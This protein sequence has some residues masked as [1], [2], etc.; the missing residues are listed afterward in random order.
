[1]NGGKL[2]L[3][4]L[5]Y[6]AIPAALEFLDTTGLGPLSIKIWSEICRNPYIEVFLDYG[7]KVEHAGI[8]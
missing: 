1:M 8:E 3:S 4:R 5:H 7:G 2:W 6:D